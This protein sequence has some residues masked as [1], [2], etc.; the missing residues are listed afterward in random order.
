MGVMEIQLRSTD[1]QLYAKIAGL[2]AIKKKKKKKKV[3]LK[4]FQKDRS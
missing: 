4:I 1:S 3:D 2:P